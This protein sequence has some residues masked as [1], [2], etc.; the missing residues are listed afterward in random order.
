MRRRRP[1]PNGRPRQRPSLL[2]PCRAG[3]RTARRPCCGCG[4]IHVTALGLGG[5]SSDRSVASV[6]G[7]SEEARRGRSEQ[8]EQ[9][10]VAL[11]RTRPNL[12]RSRA[13]NAPIALALDRSS[14]TIEPCT[15]VI[16]GALFKG[17]F[18]DIAIIAVI[19]SVPTNPAIN[20]AQQLNV[21]I[22]S[23]SSLHLLGRPAA[24]TSTPQHARSANRYPTAPTFDRSPFEHIFLP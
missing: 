19:T 21:T 22:G 8:V 4:T 13:L 15:S 7:R 9:Q 6:Q 18:D 11:G 1:P 24:T 16:F 2:G 5:L 23:P 3:P 17:V 14:V 10:R 20:A 12:S